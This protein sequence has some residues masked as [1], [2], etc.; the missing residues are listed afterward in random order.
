MR[1]RMFFLHVPT[2]ALALCASM[3]TDY[4]FVR[5]PDLS[6]GNIL[7]VAVCKTEMSGDASSMPAAGLLSTCVHAYLHVH[8]HVHV[9][10]M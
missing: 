9:H 7:V 8:L 5:L 2:C 6:L 10:P 3:G 4:A 1:M